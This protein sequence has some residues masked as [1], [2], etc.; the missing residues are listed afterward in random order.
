RIAKTILDGNVTLP[1]ADIYF[2]TNIQK[3]CEEV[4]GKR[5]FF[6]IQEKESILTSNQGNVN[7]SIFEANEYHNAGR[8]LPTGKSGRVPIT[9][10]GFSATVLFDNGSDINIISKKDA[11]ERNL[12]IT[13]TVDGTLSGINGIANPLL[14][15]IDKVP[16]IV[17]SL[18][19]HLSIFVIETLKE[20]IMGKP[21][22]YVFQALYENSLNGDQ[23]VTLFSKT[24]KMAV[25]K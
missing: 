21:F 19:A 18:V 23:F 24:K 13:Y 25:R 4:V 5:R 6:P 7:F 22:D 11:V 12:K 10:N 17:G 16:L 2:F 20:R 9:L 1:I 15:M 14:G 3:A 8:S